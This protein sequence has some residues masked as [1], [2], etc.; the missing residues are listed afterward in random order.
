MK[1]S[2]VY[3]TI[4]YENYASEFYF[5]PYSLY[6]SRCILPNAYTLRKKHIFL[7]EPIALT[8]NICEVHYGAQ[9]CPK[10]S[11]SL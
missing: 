1:Y 9:P 3:S 4:L 7:C 11:H 10:W 6:K 2:R 5:K 8:I